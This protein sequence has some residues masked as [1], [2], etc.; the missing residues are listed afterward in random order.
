MET[1]ANDRSLGVT[2]LH[3]SYLQILDFLTT[4]AFLVQGVREG[5]P[6]V[7]MAMNF[8]SNPMLGLLIVKIAAVGLGVYCWHGGRS[9]MLNRINMLFALIV[10]WNLVSL[11]LGSMHFQG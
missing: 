4:V 5:N 9:R 3:Y 8:T 10:A 7:R 2:L 1:A 11:I 6:L